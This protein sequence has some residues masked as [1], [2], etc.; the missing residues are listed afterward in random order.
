MHGAAYAFGGSPGGTNSTGSTHCS[1]GGFGGSAGA[2]GGLWG[3]TGGTGGT[4]GVGRSAGAFGGLWGGTGG[5]GGTSGVGRSASVFGGLRYGTDGTG[6]GRSARV[7]GG[8][9]CGTSGTDGVSIEG[10]AR[11]FRGVWWCGCGGGGGQRGDHGGDHGGGGWPAD[12]RRS[13]VCARL[14]GP[15][16]SF[17]G[18]VLGRVLAVPRE[19]GSR[20]G[21]GARLVGLVARLSCCVSSDGL[22]AL[23]PGTCRAELGLLDATHQGGVLASDA[24]ERRSRSRWGRAPRFLERPCLVPQRACHRSLLLEE[25]G[26]TLR[27]CGADRTETRGWDH[28]DGGGRQTGLLCAELTTLLFRTFHQGGDARAGALELLGLRRSG[29]ETC[30]SRTS[31]HEFLLGATMPGL[32]LGHASRVCVPSLLGDADIVSEPFLQRAHSAHRRVHRLPLLPHPRELGL[33]FLGRRAGGGGNDHRAPDLLAMRRVQVHEIG[34]DG[35]PELGQEGIHPG[36]QRGRALR[37]FVQ[38]I[39]R[40]PVRVD[41]GLTLSQQIFHLV[42]DRHALSQGVLGLRGRQPDPRARRLLSLRGRV[43]HASLLYHHRALRFHVGQ[44]AR[45]L[46]VHARDRLDVALE[47]LG[48]GL[49][50]L[51]LRLPLLRLGLCV[52][53]RGSHGFVVRRGL[54]MLARSRDG[55]LC[56]VCRGSEAVDEFGLVGEL[57]LEV[58]TQ[59]LELGLLR[60]DV[61]VL[62]LHASRDVGVRAWHRGAAVRGLERQSFER[63]EPRVEG[64]L[65]LWEY[66]GGLHV[67]RAQEFFGF[68][69][70]EE[71]GLRGLHR[72]RGQSLVREESFHVTFHFR[73]GIALSRVHDDGDRLRGP[74]FQQHGR[75]RSPGTVQQNGRLI[76]LIAAEHPL[77][78]LGCRPDQH[79]GR[80]GADDGGRPFFFLHDTRPDIFESIYTWRSSTSRIPCDGRLVR[81]RSADSWVIAVVRA[82]A[83]T[84]T[85]P[86]ST[87]SKTPTLFL[88]CATKRSSSP[89][90]PNQNVCDSTSCVLGPAPARR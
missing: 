4:S 1:G 42:L 72:G 5:T 39:P 21:V 85:T 65:Y 57:G 81:Q 40:A 51:E 67:L 6:V 2:F 48:V 33:H 26:L 24:L 30:R 87:R 62:L 77:G 47:R 59:G 49:F 52:F 71:L 89:G 56:I 83:S 50:P 9:R 86:P 63:P 13:G 53:Q 12:R 25:R 54:E 8:V 76:R 22:G 19:D 18:C 20:P 10:S 27:E 61:I 73:D 82:M 88:C 80:R 43:C 66:H 37:M 14:V 74:R 11:A 84:R 46:V 31:A 29:L 75:G 44:H 78:R 64:I 41:G 35:S 23:R 17:R 16:A 28:G 34:C 55:G 68:A 79:G 60:R 3:G 32:H 15:M 45:V 69:R 38:L 7:F 58:G 90:R 70:L 36:G